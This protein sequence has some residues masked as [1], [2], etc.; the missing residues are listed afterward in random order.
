MQTGKTLKTYL[1]V[2][3]ILIRRRASGVGRQVLV[4]RENLRDTPC[5]PWL[6]KKV[7]R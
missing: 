3:F 1:N 2:V 5:H 4:F 6:I 7:R